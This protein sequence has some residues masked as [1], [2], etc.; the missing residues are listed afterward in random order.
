M[1]NSMQLT[2]SEYVPTSGM[3]EQCQCSV[4]ADLAALASGLYILYLVSTETALAS[5]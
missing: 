5:F 3:L 4:S 2:S 1:S